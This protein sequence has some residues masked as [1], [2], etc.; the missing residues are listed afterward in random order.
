MIPF[1]Q[2]WSSNS[3]EKFET[4]ANQN[5][6]KCMFTSILPKL[7]AEFANRHVNPLDNPESLEG[8]PCSIQVFTQKMR[9]E[10]CMEIAKI[11]DR[12]LH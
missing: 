2:A 9:D 10:E 6:P 3:P 12:C 4:K 5:A 7:A 8:A 1:S 11:V